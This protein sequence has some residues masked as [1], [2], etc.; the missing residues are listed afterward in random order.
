M[1]FRQAPFETRAGIF[2][3]V[4]EFGSSASTGGYIFRDRRRC[5]LAACE[6]PG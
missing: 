4:E 1:L 3:P 6:Y 2:S 5:P